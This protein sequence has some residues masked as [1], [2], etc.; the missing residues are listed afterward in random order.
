MYEQLLNL[1]PIRLNFSAG[2]MQAINFVLA[3]VMF[4][5]ALGIKPRNSKCI[6][7]P[8]IGHPGIDLPTGTI[9]GHDISTD[10]DIQ[11]PHHPHV[12]H[13]HDPGGCL[14]RRKHI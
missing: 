1:D 12:S 5:V 8:K 3:L 2:G 4:G 13:G 11:Q 9:T 6:Y 14:P 10:P 7:P